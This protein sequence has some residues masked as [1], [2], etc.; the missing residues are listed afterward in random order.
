MVQEALNN[1]AR[2][3]NARHVQV[4]VATTAHLIR[5]RVA[6]D[7][8]GLT[9]DATHGAGHYGLRGMRE[10]VEGLDGTLILSHNDPQGTV[11]EARLPLS[12]GTA[13]G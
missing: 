1:V 11:V 3:A 4:C 2:H 5:V 9:P 10:R 7:G 13:Y 6:D 12:G 8:S